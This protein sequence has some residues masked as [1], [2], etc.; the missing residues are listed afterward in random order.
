L[1][2]KTS[3]TAKEHDI[4]RHKGEKQAPFGSAARTF[5]E[6][7]AKTDIVTRKHRPTLHGYFTHVFITNH[8][9]VVD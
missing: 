3:I 4:E 2:G 1:Q 9:C 5:T 8:C 6:M 7:F